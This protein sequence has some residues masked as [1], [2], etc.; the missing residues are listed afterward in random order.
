MKQLGSTGATKKKFRTMKLH[1]GRNE[2]NMWQQRS[3]KA[4]DGRSIIG[5]MVFQSLPHPFSFGYGT[6]LPWLCRFG[7][8]SR[9]IF[10][11]SKLK[12]KKKKN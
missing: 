5:A 12:E 4:A 8:E 7:G 1:R 3:N 11:L 2:T 10:L 9:T 6:E